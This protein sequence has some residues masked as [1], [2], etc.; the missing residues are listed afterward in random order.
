MTGYEEK[1]IEHHTDPEESVRPRFFNPDYPEGID[2]EDGDLPP[3]ED[4]DFLQDEDED[5][6]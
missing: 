3:Y 5:D 1:W 2:W 4:D 6:V